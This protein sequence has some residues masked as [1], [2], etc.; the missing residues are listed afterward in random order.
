MRAAANDDVQMRTASLCL[1][2]LLAV[3]TSAHA[4]NNSDAEFL[5]LSEGATTCGEYI[6]QPSARQLPLIL[7]IP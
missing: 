1:L 3:A 2:L 5:A 7:D 4:L 6:A